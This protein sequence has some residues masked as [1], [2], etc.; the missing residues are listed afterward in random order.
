MPRSRAVFAG[1]AAPL[2]LA[3]SVGAA[4][5]QGAPC[6]AEIVPLRAELEKNGLSVKAAI[7]RK[8]ERTEICNQ[9]KR[10]ASA[11]AK[12]VKYLEDNQGWCGIPP[13]IVTQVKT[14][15]GGTLNLRQRACAAAP[16]GA[17]GGRPPIPA[18]PGL[19]DALG[20]SGA[21]GGSSTAKPGRSTFDTMTGSALAR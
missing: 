20:T 8:A 14:Q 18:G 17:A 9:V 19:S 6:Q 11:E 21:V 2:A 10:Y 16:P 7:D 15:H 3:A 13:E 1:F 5:A 4:H 12:F